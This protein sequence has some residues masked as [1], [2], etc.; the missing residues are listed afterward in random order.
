MI[1]TY[2]EDG[3][4]IKKLTIESNVISHSHRLSSYP[5]LTKNI[6]KGSCSEIDSFIQTC[7][8]SHQ[9]EMHN[10]ITKQTDSNTRA[11]PKPCLSFEDFN[12]PDRLLHILAR[13]GF[14]EPTAIQAC[15]LPLALSG[16]NIIGSSATGSGKT[17]CYLLPLILHILHQTHFHSHQQGP[18]GLILVPTRELADQI[19]SVGKAFFATYKIQTMCITGGMSEW[20]QKKTLYNQTPDVIIGTP[21]RFIE[22]VNKEYCCLD[23][24]SFVVRIGH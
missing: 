21:G 14:I 3:N 2:D 12:F 18:L 10:L 24:C 16:R 4:P 22:L 19:A 9:I 15:S 13:G 6:Y 23:N 1:V 20:Q 8:E 17:L 7:I 5:P 11:L